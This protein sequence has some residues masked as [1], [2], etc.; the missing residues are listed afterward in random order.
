MF[1]MMYFTL[2]ATIATIT[3]TDLFYKHIEA[4]NVQKI[5]HI[6]NIS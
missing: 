2:F 3:E 4:E 5:K 1:L 6:L